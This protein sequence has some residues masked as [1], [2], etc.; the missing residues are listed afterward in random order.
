[1]D[2]DNCALRAIIALLESFSTIHKKDSQ[3]FDLTAL[4]DLAFDLMA[5]RDLAKVPQLQKVPK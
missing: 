4:P 3:V 1:M 5:L 2:R